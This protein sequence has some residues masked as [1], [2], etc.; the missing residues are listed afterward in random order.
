[1][2]DDKRYYIAYG[3]NLS[4]NQMAHRTPEAKIV[5]IAVLHGWRLL[6]KNYA[7][8]EENPNYDTPVLVW[9]ISPRDRDEENLDRYEGFPH[10]YFKRDL[11]VTV[12]PLDGGKPMELTAMIYIMSPK[13]RW[14]QAPTFHY[15]DIL[16]EGYEVFG[17]D[18][19]ILR[20]ALMESADRKNPIVKREKLR[21]EM[22]RL[23]MEHSGDSQ[24]ELATQFMFRW[25]KLQERDETIEDCAKLYAESSKY[26]TRRF[27]SS[28]GMLMSRAA[29]DGVQYAICSQYA[30]TLQY[31]S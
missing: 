7:T 1:M 9:D 18:K 16:D 30:W 3:S 8:I 15:Y 6:F 12:T 28:L 20:K 17:F 11:P 4:V 27:I 25:M 13:H 23:N 2:A 21:S 19:A 14:T 24:Y 10:F 29:S 31:R 26:R 5:G 22:E